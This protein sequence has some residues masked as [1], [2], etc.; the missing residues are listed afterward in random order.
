[1]LPF[2]LVDLIFLT[3][4]RGNVEEFRNLLAEYQAAIPNR[5]KMIACFEQ[6]PRD[7]SLLEEAVIGDNPEIFDIVFKLNGYD[8]NQIVD[9]EDSGFS[10]DGL[11]YEDDDEVNEDGLYH[12]P[13]WTHKP[14]H[15]ADEDNMPLAEKLVR[16]AQ[17][18]NRPLPPSFPAGVELIRSAIFHHSP[19]IL[20]HLIRA[21]GLRDD[22][23]NH[24]QS[25]LHYAVERNC[26]NV[27]DVL[28]KEGG[29]RVEAKDHYNRTPLDL[30][31]QFRLKKIAELLLK[32]GAKANTKDSEPSELFA[33]P[34]E[35]KDG[36]S[37]MLPGIGEGDTK[38]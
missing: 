28:I 23:P 3:A 26:Q 17:G 29:S 35:C 13:S 6:G 34:R 2:L 32:N 15:N 19:A 30:A 12:V 37:E 16:K 5:S 20:E 21:Y 10:S 18:K 27:I 38:M 14:N 11:E 25:A 8:V 24:Y 31:D 4:R 7:H 22:L 1:M 36:A 9:Y 33:D